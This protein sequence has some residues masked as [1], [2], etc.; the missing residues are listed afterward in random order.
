MDLE[1]AY[2]RLYKRSLLNVLKIYGIGGQSLAGV[3]TFL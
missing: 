3:K 1:K 2:D